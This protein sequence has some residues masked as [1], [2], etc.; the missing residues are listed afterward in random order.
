M[1]SEL[2]SQITLSSMTFSLLSANNSRW[3]VSG[4]F[5]IGRFVFLF[6]LRR[7]IQAVMPYALRYKK[8]YIVSKSDTLLVGAVNRPAVVF[9][10]GIYPL[11][12]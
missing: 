4:N 6:I 5:L 1:K 8:Y 7:V 12:F 10:R 11:L 3:A 2:L 9:V